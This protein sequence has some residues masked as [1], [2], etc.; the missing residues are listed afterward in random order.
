MKAFD[1]NFIK[2]QLCQISE[3]QQ[4]ENWS[5]SA[6]V[7]VPLIRHNTSE[8]SLLLTQRSA[9][10]RQH[11]GEVAFPGGMWEPGDDFPKV[12]ALREAEEEVALSPADVTTLGI[13]P[14]S[15]TGSGVA[16]TPVVGVLSSSNLS[17]TPNPDEID[18]IFQV[19]LQELVSDKRIRTDIFLRRNQQLWAPAFDYQGYEIW[20][21]TAAVIRLLLER[22]FDEQFERA[23]HAPEKLWKS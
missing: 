15:Y 6:A 4:S 8:Y 13:L 16:V 23:H 17:L 14:Q 11:G 18:S 20:G 22:C 2:C 10:L 7:L 21:F 3:A 5:G 9:N 1:I 12:T 19:P